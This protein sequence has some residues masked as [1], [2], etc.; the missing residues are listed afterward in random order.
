MLLDANEDVWH[1]KGIL[2]RLLHL[3][4]SS[5]VSKATIFQTKTLK[6]C[7]LFPDK[8][9]SL[10]GNWSG[11]LLSLRGIVFLTIMNYEWVTSPLSIKCLSFSL[12]QKADGTCNTNFKKTKHKEQVMQALED[13]VDGNVQILVCLHFTST[14]WRKMREKWNITVFDLLMKLNCKVDYLIKLS[15]QHIE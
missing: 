14:F 2:G 3:L 7:A 12:K 8:Y 4:F 5:P 13:F 15:C 9:S 6:T 1:N 10:H 11:K